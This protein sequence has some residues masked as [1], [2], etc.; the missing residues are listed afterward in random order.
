[1]SWPGRNLPGLGHRCGAS[2]AGQ[3]TEAE[4]ERC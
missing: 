3:V 1:M 2:S 4:A